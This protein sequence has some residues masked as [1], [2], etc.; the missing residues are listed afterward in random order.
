M[1]SIDDAHEVITVYEESSICSKVKSVD[2]VNDFYV[3]SDVDEQN[4]GEKSGVDGVSTVLAIHTLNSV[5]KSPK[6]W[7][8]CLLIFSS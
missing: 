5:F 8:F 1:S 4:D 3:V 7:Q 2:V 6:P